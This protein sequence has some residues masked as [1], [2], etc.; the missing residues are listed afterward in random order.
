MDNTTNVRGYY[1]GNP[2][3]VHINVSALNLS[4]TLQPNEYLKD[5]YGNIVNDPYFEVFVKNR[6]LAKEISD[7][8]V[9]VVRYAPVKTESPKPSVPVS[10][11]SPWAKL[12]AQ[13]KVAKS[14]LA[15][16]KAGN[17]T[18]S[19]SVR[20]M[21]EASPAQIKS[22]LS[23]TTTQAPKST[24]V[25]HQFTVE[26]A[27]RL[28]L[29]RPTRNIP[30][31]YGPE[32][33]S[34]MPPTNIPELKVADDPTVYSKVP[35]LPK[36]LLTPTK[37]STD[38][39]KLKLLETLKAPPA[40]VAPENPSHVTANTENKKSHGIS[41]KI[42]P[43]S[44]DADNILPEPEIEDSEEEALAVPEDL[45]DAV[46]DEVIDLANQSEP[47][48]GNVPDGSV[49]VAESKPGGGSTG[50][51]GLVD[52]ICPECG[53]VF[54]YKFQLARHQLQEHRAK[55]KRS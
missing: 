41:E 51:T 45:S 5:P 33:T 12:G 22:V 15:N 1:N 43:S 39:N 16:I 31:D 28:R 3:P 17:Q 21:P 27:R 55:N 2:W 42:E 30:D 52:H 9:P 20:S 13:E 46:L 25:V 10:A 6:Q 40:S 37:D 11:T 24:G 4:V 47:V 54:K 48:T 34:G 19:A 18:I 7:T 32:D 50:K 26:E 49:N 53:Q 14:G 35:E 8:A 44:N 38:T 23:N 29:I 36:E